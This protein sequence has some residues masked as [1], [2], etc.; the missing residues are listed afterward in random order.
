MGIVAFRVENCLSFHDTAWIEL[1]PFLFLYGE[2]S[3]GKS[4]IHR[5][6]QEIKQSLN[7]LSV[8]AEGIL[9]RLLDAQS[10][11]PFSSTYNNPPIAISFKFDILS[12]IVDGTAK[13]SQQTIEL[14]LMFIPSRE[15]DS[16]ELNE[17][18]VITS[19]KSENNEQVILHGKKAQGPNDWVFKS[20][21]YKSTLED[22]D[23]W[24]KTHIAFSFPP[25]L[26]GKNE[27]I[28]EITKIHRAQDDEGQNLFDE[29]NEPV[30]LDED[31]SENTRF[32]KNSIRFISSL[33][34][35]M[36]I[37]LVDMF[38]NYHFISSVSQTELNSDLTEI[39]SEHWAQYVCSSTRKGELSL[40][41]ENG[42][43]LSKTMH[44]IQKII[45]LRQNSI[46]FLEHPDAFLGLKVQGRFIDFLIYMVYRQKIKFIVESHSEIILLRLRKRIKQFG[47]KRPVPVILSDLEKDMQAEDI[48]SKICAV[49]L[50]KDVFDNSQA[51]TL[52]L[53]ESGEFQEI[54]F[55]PDNFF[56]DIFKEKLL[57]DD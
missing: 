55:W 52:H 9:F 38:N 48:S 49:I 44:L 8:S 3:S 27:N 37:D 18:S 20:E 5:V 51:T 54:P 6:L 31:V 46:C 33:L 16:A 30:Y 32:S 45:G 19:E 7:G 21:Y 11:M 39:E 53:N 14:K 36:Q 24:A 1:K 28:N 26:T 29:N 47:K 22:N 15:S 35:Q 17:F 40:K 12:Q 25:Q 10:L 43:G 42:T 41:K 23:V 4:N 13:L 57:L 34:S 2:N 56:D 50:K